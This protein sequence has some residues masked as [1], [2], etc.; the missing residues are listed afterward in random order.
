VSARANPTAIGA[1]VVGAI[2]L[3]VAGLV[4]LGG[5]QIFKKELPFVMFF[6]GSVGGLDVGA[7]VEIRGVKIGTV[8]RIR[9]LAQKQ[10]IGVYVSI[11]PGLLPK[12]GQVVQRGEVAVEELIKQGLRAQLQTQSL[13]TGQLLV[14]LDF[15]PDSPIVLA[16]L[17]PT[18]PEIPTV[19][20]TLA[21]LQARLE[22]LLDA[23]GKINLEEMTGAMTSTLRNASALLAS[24]EVKGTI[25]SANNALIAA[26]AALKNADQVIKRVGTK[27]EAVGEQTDAT[28]ADARRL[29]ANAQTVLSRLDAQIEPLSTSI[30]DTS[31]S[32]RG[33]LRSLDRAAEGD[34]GLGYELVRA[35]RDVADAARSLKTL[36]DY[37]ERHPDALIRGKGGPENK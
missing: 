1:F 32:A 2:A 30:Q 10:Q 31:T 18:V 16:R 11:D 36:A 21:K 35:L 23:I 15:F 37:L 34:S 5:L 3:A 19:P 4:T 20:T 29:I 8:T 33:T 17:D 13:L 14:Y 22:S 27:L 24:P 6:E 28:L 26:D 25:V 12:G 7:P 9:L